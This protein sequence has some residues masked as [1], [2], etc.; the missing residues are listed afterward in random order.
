MDKTLNVRIDSETLE[1]LKAK[2]DVG[3]VSD[4]VRRAVE[5]YVAASGDVDLSG[6]TL[7][8]LQWA[9]VEIGSASGRPL[10]SL[11]A[12]VRA[13]IAHWHITKAGVQGVEKLNSF[14]VLPSGMQI[15]YS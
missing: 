1:R 11:D 10:L 6:E 14:S 9:G 7:L 2:M 4:H 12:I 5:L 15:S 3:T 13:L 8:A